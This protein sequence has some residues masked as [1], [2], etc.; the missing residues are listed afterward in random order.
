[1]LQFSRRHPAG[2]RIIVAPVQTFVASVQAPEPQP[3]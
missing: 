2:M 3:V 1:V